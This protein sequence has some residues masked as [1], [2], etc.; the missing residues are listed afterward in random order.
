MFTFKQVRQNLTGAGLGHGILELENG[1]II[2]TER[3]GR[4]LGPFR[5]EDETPSLNWLNPVLA[6]SAAL[7]LFLA[8]NDWNLGGDRI[9]LAPEIHYMFR[10]RANPEASYLL[11]PEMD[12]GT[13]QL[14]AEGSA[15][16]KLEQNM[17]LGAYVTGPVNP[18]PREFK[19]S[20]T[21]SSIPDP[22]R[23]FPQYNELRQ[24]VSFAGYRQTVELSQTSEGDGLSA[25]WSLIQL[26]SGGEVYVPLVRPVQP[27][28]Y[29]LPDG[30]GDTHLAF[31]EGYSKLKI[32]GKHCYKVG[33]NSGYLTGR[34]AYL[35]REDAQNGYLLIRSYFNN[36]SEEY[37]EEPSHL[38]GYRGDSAFIYNDSGELGAF[39]ELECQGGTVEGAPGKQTATDTLLLWAYWGPLSRLYRIAQQL[40]QINIEVR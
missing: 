5:D 22:L 33:F 37:I 39:G 36:P 14:S 12:P 28:L 6:D 34:V 21:I 3:G 29:I 11:P 8:R 18:L 26:N 20:R 17:A 16:L 40:L 27:T 10:D 13:W 4:I 2:V 35:N 24:E 32:D 25:A 38:P 23:L 31:G 9:W 19:V 7:D 15:V 30:P 1:Y